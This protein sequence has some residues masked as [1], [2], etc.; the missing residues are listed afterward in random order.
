MSAPHE[1]PL[2]SL[3]DIAAV[4]RQLFRRWY[5]TF[6]ALG[7]QL[8]LWWILGT[9]AFF[10]TF[11]Y[12]HPEWPYGK[13]LAVSAILMSALVIVGFTTHVSSCWWLDY[14]IARR[15]DDMARRTRAGEAVRASEVR[16]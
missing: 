1:D 16:L 2:A 4:R 3:D 13:N 8:V 9:V 5:P 15:L 12:S 6:T 11:W 10:C 14:R 7:R